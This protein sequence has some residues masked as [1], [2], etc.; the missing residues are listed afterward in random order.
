MGAPTV[1]TSPDEVY[2]P[3]F[4][5]G[6]DLAVVVG[7]GGYFRFEAEDSY[8]EADNVVYVTDWV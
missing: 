2:Y 4:H 8:I 5:H 3:W 6:E 7:P 1:D